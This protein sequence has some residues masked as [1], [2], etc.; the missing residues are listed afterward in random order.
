IAR[1]TQA[2]IWIDTSGSGEIVQGNFIGTSSAGTAPLGDLFN[3]SA[4]GIYLAS[5]NATIGGTAAGQ[6]NTIAFNAA[7]GITVGASAT[8]DTIRGNSIHDNG[9]FGIDLGGD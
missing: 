9:G 4:V 7:A 5:P 8:G 3:N 1:T 6:A 2:G